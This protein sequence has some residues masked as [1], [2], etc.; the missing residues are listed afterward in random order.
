M[1]VSGFPGVKPQQYGNLDYEI[2][3]LRANRD[4]ADVH[5]QAVPGMKSFLTDATTKNV[6]SRVY[7]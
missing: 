6:L 7:S 2:S 1:D 5:V 3:L 4:F